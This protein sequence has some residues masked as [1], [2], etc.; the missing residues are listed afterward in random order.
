MNTRAGLG[1]TK[2]SVL[3]KL[4]PFRYR[5]SVA[6]ALVTSTAYRLKVTNIGMT[7]LGLWDVMACFPVKHG[8][9]VVTPTN[10]AFTLKLLTY[11]F[12]PYLLFESL[13]YLGFYCYHLWV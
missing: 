7:S 4:I 5:V 13:G 3:V 8:D 6:H 1:S 12:D 10:R 2:D 9:L 11:P